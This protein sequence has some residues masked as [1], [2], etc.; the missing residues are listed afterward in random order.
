MFVHSRRT[1]SPFKINI[2]IKRVCCWSQ[3][4]HAELGPGN[5]WLPG[6]VVQLRGPFSYLVKLEYGRYFRRHIDHL[7]I[8]TCQGTT[9]TS[10]TSSYLQWPDVTTSS[11]CSQPTV[12]T[13]PTPPPLRRS[14]RPH[15]PP[16]RYGIA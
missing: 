15:N 4:I 5:S 2:P 12:S 7:R 3:D 16:D 13:Q 1:R 10:E 6:K 9:M 14:S 11:S 8:R